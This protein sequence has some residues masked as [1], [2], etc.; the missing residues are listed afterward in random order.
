[1]ESFVPE[2]RKGFQ[3]LKQIYPDAVFPPVYFV[4]GGRNSGWYRPRTAG[5]IVAEM[6][7]D[8]GSQPIS[9]K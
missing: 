4:I 3:R 7:V 9:T 1:M 2:I 5:F 6:I 8:S